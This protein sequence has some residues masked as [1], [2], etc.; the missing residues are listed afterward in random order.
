MQYDM[1]KSYR[2][3]GIVMIIIGLVAILLPQA[4]TVVLSVFLGG[5]LILSGL[6]IGYGVWMGPRTSALAWLKPFVLVAIGLLIAF[7]PT[8]VAAALGLLLVVYFL[9]T[10][11]ASLSF[12]Y[13]LAP[14]GGRPWMIFN[15]VLSI[16]LAAVFLVGWPFSSIV[17]VGILVGISFLF[18]G[19]GLLAVS[20]AMK[21]E[22][23]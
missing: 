17:L 7:S 6:A 8:A 21:L 16:L 14:L 23:R 22:L 4:V 9:L 2:N 18:D 20:R 13:E 19:I 12:A 10:G 1:S 15:G 3:T 11:F 5:L